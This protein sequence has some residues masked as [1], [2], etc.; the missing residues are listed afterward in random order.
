MHRCGTMA[1]L[2]PTELHSPLATLAYVRTAARF[3]GR[4]RSGWLGASPSRLA[5]LS[6]WPNGAN[7]PA[8]GAAKNLK[9]TT[10]DLAVRAAAEQQGRHLRASI[11]LLRVG[12]AAGGAALAFGL[13]F[14]HTTLQAG[15]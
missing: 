11:V 10:G 6:C 3:R 15:G 2:V 9:K 12:V 5:T 14:L 7:G 8:A 4:N 13:I 1:E